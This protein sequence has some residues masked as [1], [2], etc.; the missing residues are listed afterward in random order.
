MLLGLATL[1]ASLRSIAI[2]KD[3]KEI[4]SEKLFSD[5]L[6]VRIEWH[7]SLKEAV[8]DRQKELAGKLEDIASHTESVSTLKIQQCRLEAS[9]FFEKEITGLISDIEQEFVIQRSKIIAGEQL[10][11]NAAPR[12]KI[13]AAHH[14][15]N[16]TQLMKDLSRALKPFLY[17]GHIKQTRPEAKAGPR[18]SGIFKGGLIR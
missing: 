7:E 5:L 10:L 4:A 9:W 11:D 14:A 1:A 12:A 6:K 3:A 16:V 15:G 2:A 17:V 18:I 8:S 13:E